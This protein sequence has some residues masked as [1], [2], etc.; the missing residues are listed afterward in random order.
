[1]FGV[2]AFCEI[3][4]DGLD[5][6]FCDFQWYIEVYASTGQIGNGCWKSCNVIIVKTQQSQMFE[7][8]STVIGEDRD[9]AI[10]GIKSLQ[11][12]KVIGDE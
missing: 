6:L 9:V 7:F 1:M 4:F 10:I 2:N 11:F 3:S 8:V 12:W 5:S